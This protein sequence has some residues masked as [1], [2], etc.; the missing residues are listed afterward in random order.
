MPEWGTRRFLERPRNVVYLRRFVPPR[1]VQIEIPKKEIVEKKKPK[2]KPVPDPTPEGPELFAE[3]EPEVDIPD[4]PEDAVVL[5]G[6]DPEPPAAKV[7]VTGPVKLSS[8][9][10]RPKLITRVEPEYPPLAKRAGLEGV[11]VLQATIDKEGSV[12]EIIVVRSM[13][14]AGMDE[15]AIKAVKE[16]KYTPALLNG[17]PIAVYM[18]VTVLFRLAQ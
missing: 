12:S 7:V 14:S 10:T 13:K 9:M 5:F 11:V 2:L 18:P 4:I 6:E 1:P 16:W 3:P 15:S 17:E 8:E